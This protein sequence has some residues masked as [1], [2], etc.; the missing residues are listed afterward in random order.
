M[1]IAFAPLT[2]VVRVLAMDAVQQAHSSHPGMPIGMPEIAKTLWRR[3]IRHNR[4]RRRWP[5]RD[6]FALSRRLGSM[7]ID[8]P[9]QPAGGNVAIGYP[10][11]LRSFR[12]KTF[13]RPR[14]VGT[15]RVETTICPLGRGRADGCLREGISQEAGPLADTTDLGKRIA[16]HEAEGIAHDWLVEDR[17]E[18]PTTRTPE[19]KECS[20]A[21]GC[22]A[23][24]PGRS[25]FG[26]KF[27][28]LDG[29]VIGI[30]R[31]EEPAP[32]GQLF[33]FFGFTVTHGDKTVKSLL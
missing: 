15:R 28:G 20:P 12:T 19:S 24:E 25:G 32:A 8:T 7:Q 1:P 33:D 21:T 16:W 22:L 23:M 18:F 11:V 17:T 31:L 13:R 9:P 2:S 6:R 30:D 3:H 26:R 5:D 10:T 29:T 27:V 14:V 4:A